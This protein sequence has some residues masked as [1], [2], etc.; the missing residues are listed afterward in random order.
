MGQLKRLWDNTRSDRACM[1][2]IHSSNGIN[3]RGDGERP[4]LAARGNPVALVRCSRIPA[5][6]KQPPGSRMLDDAAGSLAPYNIDAPP[7]RLPATPFINQMPRKSSSSR[8]LGVH[9]E[10]DRGRRPDFS[11]MQMRW[12]SRTL[13]TGP[14]GATHVDRQRRA[15]SAARPWETA[16]HTLD[17][18]TSLKDS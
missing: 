1:S 7:L 9:P 14:S 11:A 18:C 5:A 4:A 8:S 13:P 16:A 17:G 12:H 15:C 3:L 6:P 2:E 10:A